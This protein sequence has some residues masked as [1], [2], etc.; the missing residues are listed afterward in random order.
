MD[1]PYLTA[2]Q[3]GI[4]GKLKAKPEDFF[5]EEIPLYLPTGEGQHVYAQ[6]EKVGLSTHAAI[7]R[8]AR[9]LS[10]SPGTIGYAGLK[11]AQAVTRQTISIDKVAPQ[12]VAA[13]DLPNIKI[14]SVKPHTNKLKTGHLAGNRFVIRVSEVSQAALPVAEGILDILVKKGAPNFFGEQR[15]GN[16]GNT[17]RL[18]EMLVRKNATEF[19][20]EYL[21]RP[22]PQEAPHVRAARQLI[23]ERHWADALA[24]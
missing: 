15:F 14:L 6:I 5:V 16:R 2:G 17:D 8:V 3:P 23:D 10:V 9:A 21:G 4:G 24:C 19:V 20:A 7:K 1:L 13:L 22:Q 18:G 12:T 11:D